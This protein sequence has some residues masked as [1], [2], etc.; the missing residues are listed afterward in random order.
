M[1]APSKYSWF[2]SW[3]TVGRRSSIMICGPAETNDRGVDREPLVPRT[4]RMAGEHSLW[5]DFLCP[6]TADTSTT[7]STLQQEG[8]LFA[9]RKEGNE[10]VWLVIGRTDGEQQVGHHRP[11]EY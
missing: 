5:I 4:D 10:S 1:N 3:G 9:W 11:V 8:A 2:E 6:F 7:S